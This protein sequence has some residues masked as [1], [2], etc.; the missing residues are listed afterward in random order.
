MN[1]TDLKNMTQK[2]IDTAGLSAMER[3][4]LALRFYQGMNR[5][6]IRNRLSLSITKAAELE[7]HALR[8]MR[9]MPQRPKQ[10]HPSR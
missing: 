10:S 1:N 4:V 3:D 7:V 6:E 8:K 2:A 5:A 9:N